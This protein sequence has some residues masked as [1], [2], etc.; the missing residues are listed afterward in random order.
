MA[1]IR[2]FASRTII[3]VLGRFPATAHLFEVGHQ[4]FF[5][6]ILQCLGKTVCSGLEVARVGRRDMLATGWDIDAESLAPAGDGDGRLRLQKTCDLLAKLTHA[7]LQSSH[8][9]PHFDSL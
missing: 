7:D 4:L 5:I 3:S 9:P 8:P 1:R 2:M 6:N